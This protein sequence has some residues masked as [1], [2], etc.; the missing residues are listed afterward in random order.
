ME[1]IRKTTAIRTE[2]LENEVVGCYAPA[3]GREVVGCYSRPAKGTR[4][5]PP[6]PKPRRKRRGLWIF[7]TCLAILLGVSLGLWFMSR[8]GAASAGKPSSPSGSGE[9]QDGGYDYVLPGEGTTFTGVKIPAWPAEG[10]TLSLSQPVGEALTPQGVYERV[11]PAVVTVMVDLVGGGGSVGTGVIF[12]ENGYLLTNYHVIQGGYNCSVALADNAQ[13]EAHYVA[14]DQ[15]ND[16]AVL[17]IITDE[18]LPFAQ[19]GD[20]AALS[21]GDPVY[22]IGSPL[23]TELRGTFTN[24]IVSALDRDVD[25][26]GRTMIFLQTNAAL[27]TGNSGGPLINVYGQVVG[28][29]TIKMSSDFST[30][31]GLGFAI[32]TDRVTRVVNDLLTQGF[33]SPEPLLGITLETLGTRLPDGTVGARVDSVSKGSAAEAAGVLAEDYIVAADGEAV[34]GSGDLLRIRGRFTVGD[35]MAVRVWR[36]GKYIDLVLKLEQTAE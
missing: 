34:S 1:E 32:P 28:I 23:G 21:V 19:I 18:K 11:G 36:N 17:K 25:V 2:R 27:N 10:V 5:T 24:G 4:E 13:Y 3:A 33:V 14:G 26:D 12:T 6:A 9:G 16:V 15:V 29:N 20:P 8:G 30:V 7:L 22:A 31:E 35:E